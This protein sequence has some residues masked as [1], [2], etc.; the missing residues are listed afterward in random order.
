MINRL[1]ILDGI[2]HSPQP[3]PHCIL[4]LGER[5]LVGA[6]DEQGHGAGVLTLLNEGVFLLSLWKTGL[7][8]PVSHLLQQCAHKFINWMLSGSVLH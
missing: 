1:T 3:I 5:V 6:P 8:L 7:C 4:D 2:F